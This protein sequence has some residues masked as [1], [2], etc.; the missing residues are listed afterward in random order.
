MQGKRTDRLGEQLR[1]EL[2]D[3]IEHELSDPR[4]GFTTVT[5]VRV[6]PD[7]S[8]ARVYVSVIGNDEARKQTLQGLNSA[9]SFIRRKL[10]SRLQHL[11]HLP[12]LA[13]SY[14]DSLEHGNR[15]EELLHKIHEDEI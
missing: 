2:S 1:L 5:H 4:I 14:D 12:E 7:L 9:R 11:R 8:H 6:S 13:F 3:I 10:S 15:I